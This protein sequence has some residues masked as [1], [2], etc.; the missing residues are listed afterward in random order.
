MKDLR[1]QKRIAAK[2]LKCSKKRVWLDPDNYE[3]IKEAITKSDIRGLI[4]DKVIVSKQKKGISKVRARKRQIQKSKGR[5]RGPGSRKGT[6]NARLSKKKAWINAVRSQRRLLKKLFDNRLI[7]KS[8]Y[9]KLYLKVKGGFFRSVRHIK[10]FIEEH[11]LYK[12]NK[13]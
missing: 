5:R 8:T 4:H 2:L 9:R 10:L 12:R 6:E 11:G 1:P 7:D 13:K 3:K